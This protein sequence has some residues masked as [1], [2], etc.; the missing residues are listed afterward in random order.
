MSDRNRETIAPMI[1]AAVK[2]YLLAAAPTSKIVPIKPTKAM[3]DAVD[4]AYDAFEAS[5]DGAWCGAASVYAAMLD[6]APALESRPVALADAHSK[7]P[8]EAEHG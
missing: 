4:A 6:A 5:A 3:M 8:P 1:L 2:A 7:N